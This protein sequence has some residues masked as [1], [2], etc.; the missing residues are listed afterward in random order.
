MKSVLHQWPSNQARAAIPVSPSPF[1]EKQ[2][3]SPQYIQCIP[4]VSSAEGVL[5]EHS[6]PGAREGVTDITANGIALHVR[7]ETDI[8]A[9]GIALHVRAATISSGQFSTQPAELTTEATVRQMKYI[10]H[11]TMRG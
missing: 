6:R 3:D 7:A 2:R 4:P 10:A 8:T 1:K 11:G 5:A 9:K